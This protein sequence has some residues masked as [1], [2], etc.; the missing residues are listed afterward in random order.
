MSYSVAGEGL[1]VCLVFKR[2]KDYSDGLTA[3][4]CGPRPYTGEYD[5]LIEAATMALEDAY[6]PYSKFRV[7]AAILGRNGQIYSAGNMENASSGLSLC[8]ER[9]AISRAVASG[10]RQFEALAV[11]AD[12]TKP[13]AP[14]GICRQNLIEF[15]EEIIVIMANLKG[16]AVLATAAELLP[17][18]FTGRFLK[19]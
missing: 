13:I 8:A 17:N 19:H 1:H 7:G 11:V 5:N 12:T 18:A 2:D 10:E 9:A 6:A 4:R 14:C 3:L 16:D 15:G